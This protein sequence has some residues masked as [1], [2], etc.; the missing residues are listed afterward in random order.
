VYEDI[1]VRSAERYVVGQLQLNRY[2]H[3]TH[4]L[5]HNGLQDSYFSL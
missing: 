3:I 1:P 5:S 4:T 2:D